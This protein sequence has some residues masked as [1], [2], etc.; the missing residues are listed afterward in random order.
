MGNRARSAPQ[1]KRNV[2]YHFSRLLAECN[3]SLDVEATQAKTVPTRRGAGCGVLDVVHPEADTRSHRTAMSEPQSRSGSPSNQTPRPSELLTPGTGR[4]ISSASSQGSLG[5]ASYYYNSH[6]SDTYDFTL[7]PAS[8]RHRPS[9]PPTFDSISGSPRGRAVDEIAGTSSVLH[10]RNSSSIRRENERQEDM[11]SGVRSEFS[12][13]ASG[14]QLGHAR[15]E[16]SNESA[17]LG[18]PF[19]STDPFSIRGEDTPP[20]ITLSHFSDNNGEVRAIDDDALLADYTHAREESSATEGDVGKFRYAQLPRAVESS[21]TLSMSFGE[22]PQM[23]DSPPQTPGTPG[24]LGPNSMHR[25]QSQ[26]FNLA[27]ESEGAALT[28]N[29]TQAGWNRFGERD[30]IVQSPKE[31]L[32]SPTD[33]QHGSYFARTSGATPLRLEDGRSA[34]DAQSRQIQRSSADVYAQMAAGSGLSRAQT[35]LNRMGKSLRRISRRVI[36]LE[37]NDRDGPRSGHIRL[38]DRDDDES[39]DGEEVIATVLDKPSV[40][41]PFGLR[42]KSLGIFGP[43]NPIR[44]SLFRLMNEVWVEPLILA[45]IV[46]SVVLFVIQS[47]PDVYVSPRKPGYF[48]YW[49]DYALLVVFGVFTVELLARIII[50]GLIINPPSIYEPSNGE[51]DVIQA[52]AA[53]VE[54]HRRRKASR[55]NTMDTFAVMGDS[56]KSRANDVLKP[57]EAYRRGVP[58][59]PNRSNGPRTVASDFLDQ[60]ANSPPLDA[61]QHR[62]EG[63]TGMDNHKGTVSSI[64]SRLLEK[65]PFAKAIVAQRAHAAHYAYLRHSWNR[66]DLVAVL[67]FWVMF[68]L[69]LTRE[70][71]TS[72][73][74]IY[75]FR[76]L[77]VLRASRL[78]TVTSGTS[79]ILQSLKT[80]GPLLVNVA[81]FTAFSMLLFSVI[82]IQAFKGSYRRSCVWV[83]DLHPDVPGSAGTNYTLSQIC[84]GHYNSSGVALGRVRTDGFS[85]STTAKG[86]ICP[87][88]QICVEGDQNPEGGN[89]SFDNI[90]ESLLQ[91]IIVISCECAEDRPLDVPLLTLDAPANGWSG[92]MYDMIDAD[93]F[94]SCLYF[95]IG[96]I[97]MNFWM[98]NLFVAVITNTFASITAETKQSAFAARNI[99]MGTKSAQDGEPSAAVQRRQRVANVYKRV[100]GY[101]KFFWL[102]LVVADLGV[103]ASQASHSPDADKQRLATTEL[104]ITIAFDV[105]ILLRFFSYLLD[106]DWRSFF[107]RRRNLFDLFLAVI[108]S[109][110]Q[111]PVIKNS[112]AYAWLTVFQLARFYRVIVAVP[113]MEA[114]LI[115]VFGSMSGLFNMILFLLLMVGLACLIAAQLFRGDIPQEDDE[116][117]SVE[118]NFKHIFNSFLAMYQIFSSENWTTILFSALSNEGQYRQAVIAGIFLCGWFLFA[119]FIILQMFIAVIA[120]NF[121]VAEGQKRAQQLEQYLRKM[122]KPQPSFAV[123]TLHNLSP[124]RW[125]RERNQAILEGSKGERG[126]GMAKRAVDALDEK[127][128]NRRSLHTLVS[129]SRAQKVLNVFRKVLRLDRPEEQVPLDTL[130]ARQFRQSFSGATLLHGRGASMYDTIGSSKGTEDAANCLPATASSHE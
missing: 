46:F 39:S 50:S 13:W 24:A 115:R 74:H 55:S 100:W 48:D 22:Q 86:Y 101:T 80:A 103:Q 27:D 60:N 16:G 125:L 64:S 63:S 52:E 119:N 108:T 98:A 56:I 7:D 4:H 18:P 87:T 122:E 126:P 123:R 54:G 12:G 124:Y 23:A 53:E 113:R 32:N 128:K 76:A 99:D 9:W 10:R 89:S 15:G 40:Q 2:S 59:S 71:M 96:L 43:D 58:L 17:A 72:S 49:V 81:F 1:P 84:G 107:A 102:A 67:S 106:N 127:N 41:T 33:H 92:T 112:A 70:E 110:M 47:A 97:V 8:Q 51:S 29:Q 75:V 30:G 73:H 14:L 104:Y 90:F 82:G 19:S 62:P 11:R 88:G 44:T 130:Q 25:M 37:G 28:S 34:E 91:V 129:P 38:A 116:G 31:E 35:G 42:G 105:E 21:A 78:L 77:S 109:I 118:M 20:Q 6:N 69:A 85:L 114:L 36:N 79:T 94:S 57:H 83:G 61:G 3:P 95:I 66:I 93:Y 111:V 5:I 121:G 26:G 45:M 65:T 117:E 120:E 68:F